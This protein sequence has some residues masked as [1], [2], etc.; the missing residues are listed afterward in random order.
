MPLG[1]ICF[2]N[3]IML[4]WNSLIQDTGLQDQKLLLLLPVPR[5]R[6]TIGGVALFI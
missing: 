4:N 3:I 2:S 6:K 1:R 5:Q